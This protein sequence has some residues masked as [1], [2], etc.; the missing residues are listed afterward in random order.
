MSWERT[1]RTL[2]ELETAVATASTEEQ[3]QAVGGL[4]RDALISAAQ[5]VFKPDI[6]W[7]TAGP[8]P[9]PTDSKRQLEAYLG[10]ALAGTSNETTRAFAR[11]TVQLADAITH[12][13]SAT[14]KDARLAAT[15][16]KF[17]I[18]LIALLDD[19]TMTAATESWAGVQVGTRFFA[20]DGPRLH[21][22][23]DRQ[24]IG[25][26]T[27]VIEA[28][29]AAGH[30]PSFGLHAK[31]R[32]HLAGGAFQVFETD[33]RTW[34]RELLYADDGSQVLLVRTGAQGGAV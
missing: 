26:P 16:A 11:S 32:H 3:C 18:D 9:S 28:L 29:K 21:A 20:W 10:F 22:L 24:P 4:A 19:H 34:R 8:V 17:L 6:H 31:L 33:R 30:T 14:R 12:R 7:R 13:R 1:E 5:A 2:A 23:E 27:E 15:A 25:A